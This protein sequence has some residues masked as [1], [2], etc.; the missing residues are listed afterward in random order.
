M[1]VVAISTLITSAV[2]L[3][4]TAFHL[5]SW[6]IFGTH[7]S[8]ELQLAKNNEAKLDS[9]QRQLD[10]YWLIQNNMLQDTKITTIEKKDYLQK[11]KNKEEASVKLCPSP[12]VVVVV[13]VEMDGEETWL[14]M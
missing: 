3:S 14:T 13:M 7:E 6:L 1:S 9:I 4:A 12:D 10:Q 2:S 11:L 8:K 5:T